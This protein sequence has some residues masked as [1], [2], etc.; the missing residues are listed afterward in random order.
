M[1]STSKLASNISAFLRDVLEDE[2][3]PVIIDLEDKRFCQN[4]QIAIASIY[5]F[6][7]DHE[8]S[9]SDVNAEIE[10]EYERNWKFQH[11]EIRGSI[12]APRAA[13]IQ[14]RASIQNIYSAL[15]IP[16]PSST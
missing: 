16:H 4:G 5:G 14:N 9:S 3:E 15:G 6:A 8:V 2:A 13:G 1:S 7:K 10:K 11:P 12:D